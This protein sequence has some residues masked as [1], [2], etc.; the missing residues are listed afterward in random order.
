METIASKS[1]QIICRITV[2]VPTG[3]RK[4]S[5]S[6]FHLIRWTETDYFI[7]YGKG[8]YVLEITNGNS[9]SFRKK[10]IVAE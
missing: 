9:S 4:Q 2:I 6:N 10:L 5:S 1:L 8:I 7:V 3:W